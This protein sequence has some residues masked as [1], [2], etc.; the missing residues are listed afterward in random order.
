VEERVDVLEPVVVALD[1]CLLDAGLAA[2]AR[3]RGFESASARWAWTEPERG[4]G[5]HR[6]RSSPSMNR[7][8]R[9]P[10][11]PLAAA[12]FALPPPAFFL[13]LPFLA[14]LAAGSGASKSS[15]GSRRSSS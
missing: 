1:E 15:S 14:L 5:T 2:R 8:G 7:S 9:S 11:G 13:A 10:L 4:R 6:P 3:S 12:P